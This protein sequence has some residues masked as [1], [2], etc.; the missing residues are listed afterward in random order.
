MNLIKLKITVYLYT[1]VCEMTR[2]ICKV[3]SIIWFR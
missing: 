2:D 3:V 1:V